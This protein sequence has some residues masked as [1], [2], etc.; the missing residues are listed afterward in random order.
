MLLED[1]PLDIRRDM[2]FQ[3]DGAPA[4]FHRN[5][6]AF[7]NEF[8]PNRWIGRGGA[9]RWPP[10]SPDLNPLDFFLWGHYK[11]NV[12]GRTL[13]ENQDDLADRIAQATA[14][15]TEEMLANCWENLLKRARKYIEVGGGHFEHLI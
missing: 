3:H 15:V 7:L 2:W 4:H 5:V 13:P 9:I 11:A 10:R 8:Y 6:R 12:Y 1:V 14:T